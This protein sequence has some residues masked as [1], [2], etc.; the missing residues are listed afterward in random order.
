M[1]YERYIFIAVFALLYL[2]VLDGPLSFLNGIVYNVINFATGF[3]DIMFRF[4][5]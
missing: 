3:V 5:F 2:G 4:L 1:E